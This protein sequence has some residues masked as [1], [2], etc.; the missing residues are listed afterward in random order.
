METL[1][2]IGL[3][4][5]LGFAILAL[6]LAAVDRPVPEPVGWD[7]ALLAA[8]GRSGR[9]AGDWANL[10]ACLSEHVP[11]ALNED[12]GDWESAAWFVSRLAEGA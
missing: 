6:L 8:E 9:A 1:L 10:R 7:H 5:G 11:G 4:G 12:P 3:A 2:T